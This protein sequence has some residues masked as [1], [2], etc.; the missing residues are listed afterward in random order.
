MLPSISVVIP[1]LNSERILDKC[2]ASIGKQDYPKEKIEI[3]ITDGGSIDNTKGI[4]QKYTSKILK[5]PLKTA[6][7]GKAVGIKAAKNDLI[8]LIDSD[9]ILPEKNWFKK[10]VEPFNNPEIIGSEPVK[11]THR[12]QDSYITRY[13]ALL[14]MNDPLCYFL[15]NYDRY[16]YLSNKWTGFNLNYKDKK[17]YYEITLDKRKI[18]TIGA[19]GTMIRRDLLIK[20]PLGDYFFDIDFIYFLTEKGYRKFAKVKCSIIHLFSGNIQLFCFKQKRRIKD[21]LYYNKLGIRAYPWGSINTLG[22]AKFIFYCL[23]FFPLVFQSIKGYF[24]KRDPVWFLH[25]IFCEATFLI[26]T[27]EKIK[28]LFITSIMPREKWNE[29]IEGKNYIAEDYKEPPPD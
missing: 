18:P 16:S 10:M 22:L 9:N 23:T 5:N 6:E 20:F 17:N 21:F 2:L 29:L 1:T 26:Y 11:Y 19:N 3:I 4:A 13:C 14:G 25:P 8:A 12:E 28:S 24:K 27:W 7:A 15:G